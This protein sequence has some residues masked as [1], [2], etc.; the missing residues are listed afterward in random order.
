[1]SRHHWEAYI[2]AYS[3]PTYCKDVTANNS[4]LLI[5]DCYRPNKVTITV[6]SHGIMC[7]VENEI[8]MT[9]PQPPL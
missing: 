7:R 5:V 2:L 4:L 8:E 1:M 9:I 3:R 6:Y